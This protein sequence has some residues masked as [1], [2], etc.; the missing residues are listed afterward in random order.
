MDFENI[1]G[2]TKTP[3]YYNA[4]PNCNADARVT[5]IALPNLQIVQLKIVSKTS[6]LNLLFTIWKTLILGMQ[7]SSSSKKSLKMTKVI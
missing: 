4:D 5:T 7:D 3:T 2:G 1:W 6:L